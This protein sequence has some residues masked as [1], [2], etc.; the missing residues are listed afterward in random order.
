M[1]K[2]LTFW[3][4]NWSWKLTHAPSYLVPGPG[5]RSIGPDNWHLVPETWTLGTSVLNLPFNKCLLKDRQIHNFRIVCS[6]E[7]KIAVILWNSK[8]IESSISFSLKWV[9][10]IFRVSLFHGVQPFYTIFELIVELVIEWKIYD[11]YVIP[12]VGET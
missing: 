7:V 11:D 6:C 2:F 10:W 5:T 8:L 1:W 9:H 12:A 4:D 3:R